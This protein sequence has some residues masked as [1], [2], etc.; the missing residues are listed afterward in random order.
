[1]SFCRSQGMEPLVEVSSAREM[2]IALDCGARVI[3]V[4]NRNLHDFELD[5]STTQR[6][7]RVLQTRGLS[8]HRDVV[9]AA[10]SGITSAADVLR[11]KAL[12]VRCCLVGETLMKAAD[13]KA[14]IE[15]LLSTNA[16]ISTS[17]SSCSQ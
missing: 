7:M 14:K 8:P 13:P 10:L 5:M 2:E 4:N 3:G 1:M 6:A 16:G 17:V 15:E 12:G 9:I 11:F